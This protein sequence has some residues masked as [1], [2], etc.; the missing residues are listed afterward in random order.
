MEYNLC[1]LIYTHY[2]LKGRILKAHLSLCSSMAIGNPVWSIKST[3]QL[4]IELMM[5]FLAMLCSK[6]ITLVKI[7]L[8]MLLHEE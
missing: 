3:E 4:K 8:N 6:I 7:K 2:S 5:H 1:S